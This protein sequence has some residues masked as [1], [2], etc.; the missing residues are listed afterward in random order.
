MGVR[1]PFVLFPLLPFP[2]LSL[3]FPKLKHFKSQNNFQPFTASQHCATS[4]F[5]TSHFTTSL[6]KL[7]TAHIFSLAAASRRPSSNHASTS[8][9]TSRRAST[10]LSQ[11]RAAPQH[12]PHNFIQQSLFITHPTTTVN[13]QS[14][15]PKYLGRT[16]VDSPGKLLTKTPKANFKS[17]LPLRNFNSKLSLP[18]FKS[19]L[20]LR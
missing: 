2:S 16:G 10:S 17:K 11:L 3:R 15:S 6:S 20:P 14:Q 5:K 1:P 18:H 4:P 13:M 9:T 12:T 8:L 19:M 7:H